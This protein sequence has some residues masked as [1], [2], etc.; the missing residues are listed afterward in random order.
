M[1]DTG[2]NWEVL[3]M[4]G[5]REFTIYQNLSLPYEAEFSPLTGT[6]PDSLGRYPLAAAL[7]NNQRGFLLMKGKIPLG[8]MVIRIEEIR[9]VS[10]FYIVPGK[11]RMGCGLFLAGSVFSL[12]PGKWH[13]RQIKGADRATLFWRRIL[14][15][16]IPNGYTEEMAED[17]FW[18]IVTRQEFTLR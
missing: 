4:E 11:R 10:E 14:D 6:L 8:F 16:L 5:V 9:D 1:K 3:P 2:E 15:Q 13:V 12:F 7:D 17:S 18:G